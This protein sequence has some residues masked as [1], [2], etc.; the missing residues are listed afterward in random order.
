VQAWELVLTLAASAA[1]SW[2]TATL[3]SRSALL[4]M[5]EELKAQHLQR[6]VDRKREL[7]EEAFE[8]LH[9]VVF[10]VLR[11]FDEAGS[12]EWQ[13]AT[14]EKLDEASRLAARTA[15]LGSASVF[16]AVPKLS[17]VI[18]AAVEKWEAGTEPHRRELADTLSRSLT[19]VRDLIQA[20]LPLQS[21]DT[22]H[23]VLRLV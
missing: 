21:V 8:S 11:G 22:A 7:Y 5:R 4:R 13:N 16:N 14:A 17:L 9:A 19:E 12:P 15:V 2:V 6:I 10:Q 18:A 1:I 23:E 3:Q 20:D